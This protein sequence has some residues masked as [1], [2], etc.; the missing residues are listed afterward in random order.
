MFDKLIESDT[1][2]AEFKNRSR[3]FTVSSIIVGI[4]F[5]TAVVYSLYASEIGLGNLNFE[6]SELVAP[7]EATE[8]EIKT[9]PDRPATADQP[10]TP[11]NVRS[12]MAR[13]D[14]PTI[15]PTS[16]STNRNTE[17][18]R[19]WIPFDPKLPESFG[20]GNPNSS[21]S[22]ERTNGT[23]AST[24]SRSSD[25]ETDVKTTEQPPVALKPK[26]TMIKISR[27]LNGSATSLPKPIYPRPAQMLNIEGTVRV[28]VTID[29][30]GNV[31]SAKAADGHP[32]FRGVAEQA[33]RGAKFKPTLLNDN[34]VKVTGVIVYNFKRQ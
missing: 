18:A 13:V 20:S 12:Y 15:V 19:T 16:T 27:V 33:A 25:A 3:Y 26:P 7:L 6:V 28:Q 29:E 17:R 30:N 22:G 24:G 9:E 8:P 4:L 32:L 21:G 34:A 11:Q 31:V 1:A 10:T 5:L 23:G 2:G 14:E